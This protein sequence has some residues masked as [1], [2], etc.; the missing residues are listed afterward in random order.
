[1]KILLLTTHLNI[2]GISTYVVSLAKALKDKGE[3]VF[4]A[5]SGGVLVS[6][7]THEGISHIKINIRTKNQFY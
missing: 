6:E 2:G 3:E 5:S 1:M 7:L 4:V